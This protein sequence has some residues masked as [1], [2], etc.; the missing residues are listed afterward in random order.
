MPPNVKIKAKAMQIIG[1]TLLFLS[2]FC[3]YLK[4]I[5]LTLKFYSNITTSL[6]H[7]NILLSNFILVDFVI[8]SF[9]KKSWKGKWRSIMSKELLAQTKQ[10]FLCLT[11]SY[12]VG[13]FV[14]MF[15][16]Y[17]VFLENLLY[18]GWFPMKHA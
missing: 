11:I 4:H 5:L 6:E 15:F 14:N 18:F 8:I 17:F 16:S 9:K 13:L 1:V 10:R 12:A 3:Y 2:L 7:V